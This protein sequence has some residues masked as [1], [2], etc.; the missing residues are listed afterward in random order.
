LSY[1]DIDWLDDPQFR[2]G[3]DTVHGVVRSEKL[4]VQTAD[5]VDRYIDALTLILT[6]ARQRFGHALVLADLRDAPI[7]SQLAA[8]RL[9]QHNLKLYHPGERVALLVSSSLLK[10]Q[11]RRNLVPEYQEIFMSERAAILWLQASNYQ[12]PAARS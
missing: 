8:E 1:A 4:T 2:V 10:M 11:L 5:D 7:R 12:L 3:I 9:R 6:G